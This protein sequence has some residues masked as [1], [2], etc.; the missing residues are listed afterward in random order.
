MHPVKL[1]RFLGLKFFCRRRIGL[2]HEFFDQL[3]GIEAFRNQH[4][5]DRAVGLQ[6]DLSLRQVEFQPVSYTHLTLPTNREV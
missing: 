3:V 1:R 2:D 4:A 5:V 6:Q